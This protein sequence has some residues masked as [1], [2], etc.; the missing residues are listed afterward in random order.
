MIGNI[1]DQK[2]DKLIKK[3]L[4]NDIYYISSNTNNPEFYLKQSD[5]FCIPSFREGFGLSVIEASACGLPVVTSN[6]YGLNDCMINEITGLKFDLSDSKNLYYQLEKL[7][8]SPKLRMQLGKN[9]SDFV[10]KY[11]NQNDVVT[12]IL[13]ILKKIV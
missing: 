12:F 9:G 8:T 4:N 5:I 11:F 6:I 3:N 13:N 1:E 7:I 2:L 10:K